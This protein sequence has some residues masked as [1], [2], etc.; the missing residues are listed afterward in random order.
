MS[1]PINVNIGSTASASTSDIAVP[2]TS[3][4]A[5]ATASVALSALQTSETQ[6]SLPSLSARA[7][8]PEESTALSAFTGLDIEKRQQWLNNTKIFW[9]LDD[10]FV[11]TTQHFHQLALNPSVGKHIITL[12]DENGISVSRQFEIVEKEK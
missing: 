2:Q 7:L 10:E 6:V 4:A 3:T 11:A 8:P 12:V 5:S 1:T 9:S